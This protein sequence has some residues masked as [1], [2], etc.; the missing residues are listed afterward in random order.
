MRLMMLFVFVGCGLDTSGKNHCETKADCLEGL[1]CNAD[2]TCGQPT[3]C[4]LHECGS[5]CGSV[6]DGC[7]GMMDCGMCPVQDHCTDGVIGWG[8]TDVDCG[9]VCNA[10]ATG[11]TCNATS[12]C[13][14]GTCEGHTCLAGTWTTAAEMPTAR[15]TLGA[16][17]VGGLI[18]AIGGY[19]L[20]G[21]TGVV[22]VYNPQTDSWTTKA[23]MPTPRYG[24]GIAVGG[25]GL[26][27]TV[28]GQY[29]SNTF[30]DGLSVV[31][32]AYNPTTNAWS[33]KPS[34][35]NGRYS[36]AAAASNGAIYVTGG[37][38]VNPTELLGTAVE[39]TPGDVG[40]TTV[41]DTMTTAR[42]SHASIAT[43]DG[44][45]YA[46]G[47][48]PS[49]GET[50]A[51]ESYK[52]GVAGWNTV[53]PLPVALKGLA[54][55]VVHDKVFTFG[56]NYPMATYATFVNSYN[57]ATHT[58]TK[59]ASLVHGR[60]GHS[61]VTASNGRVYVLGGGGGPQAANTTSA[62]DVYVPDP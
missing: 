49:G 5:Q 10:C 46:I 28:G 41:A 58:W 38:S 22:E 20:S 7:G 16:V 47:G 9:G 4:T 40:W 19:T 53:A 56:G 13:A 59:A 35:P 39:Y 44:T 48:S 42:D 62:V 34:L 57:P 36:T 61:A 12:D 6:S 14:T 21:V 30:T 52:P 55:A 25:D 32:E 27:Y 1:T 37:I 11:L 45:V 8:E 2:H 3:S 54:A 24:F 31:V 50:T 26:I 23:P 15:T 29:D 43:S 51:V 33:T 17:A 60:F 18:Y